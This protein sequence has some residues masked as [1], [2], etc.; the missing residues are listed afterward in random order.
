MGPSW[1]A[2]V[3]SVDR[4]LTIL[5]MLAESGELG[6]TEIAARLDVHKSTAFRLLGS[7]EQHRL[8]KQLGERGKYRLG[9]GIVRLAGATTAG[10]TSR[11]KAG[12]LP[13]AGG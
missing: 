3:Q 8:V 11:A 7:L 2:P 1:L 5:Q 10:W 13:A 9:F 12:R 6:V 4:A